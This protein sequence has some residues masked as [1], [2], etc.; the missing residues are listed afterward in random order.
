M[1]LEFLKK[2]AQRAGKYKYAALVI[3]IGMGILLWPDAAKKEAAAEVPVSAVSAESE[4]ETLQKDLQNVLSE[5]SGVGKIRVLL[6]L[7]SGTRSIF[8]QDPK[9]EK[10]LE[11]VYQQK[12]NEKLPAVSKTVYPQYR[13]ALIVC[14]GAENVS[15]CLKIKQ[16]VSG[17]TGLGSDKITIVKMKNE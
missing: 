4:K 16:A 7:E 6:S 11:T 9:T 17:L 15:V 10:E 13:G 8:W 14:E 2:A 12:G 3:L 5:M 1:K